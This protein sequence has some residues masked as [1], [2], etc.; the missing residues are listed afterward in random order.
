MAVP[1][2]LLDGSWT[3]RPGVTTDWLGGRGWAREGSEAGP[4]CLASSHYECHALKQVD[5]SRMGVPLGT[6]L[7]IEIAIETSARH[8]CGGTAKVRCSPIGA[9]AAG[10]DFE[11]DAD[12]YAFDDARPAGRDLCFNADPDPLDDSGTNE[13]YEWAVP[14]GTPWDEHTIRT[15][16][17]QLGEEI[18]GDEAGVGAVGFEVRI[19]GRDDRYWAGHYGA[20]LRAVSLTVVPQAAPCDHRSEA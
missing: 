1:T 15:Q 9:G 3:F 17:M 16:P 13:C 14:P 7:T 6:W 10:G 2:V 20:K 18:A 8:D 11:H 19:T 4:P 5:L 12:N